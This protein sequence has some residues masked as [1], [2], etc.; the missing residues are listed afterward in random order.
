MARLRWLGF[1]SALGPFL[2]GRLLLAALVAHDALALA[3]LG[4][5]RVVLAVPMLPPDPIFRSHDGFPFRFQRGRP[6]RHRK[7]PI[8]S[9]KIGPAQQ[10]RWFGDLVLMNDKEGHSQ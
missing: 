8:A 6:G 3:V 2:V 5:W 10:E 1:A 9:R 4:L 7:V